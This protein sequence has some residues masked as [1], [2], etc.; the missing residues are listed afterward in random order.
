VYANRQLIFDSG[1][2]A[3]GTHTIRIEPTGQPA[4]GSSGARVVVDALDLLGA[5]PEVAP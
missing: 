3:E 5:D 2:L 1:I 4:E